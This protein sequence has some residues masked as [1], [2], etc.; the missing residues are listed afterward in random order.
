MRALELLE[1]GALVL[2]AVLDPLLELLEVLADAFDRDLA[3][4]RGGLSF[5]LGKV[6]FDHLEFGA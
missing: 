3:R 1:E 2:G 5:E 4:R 6:R